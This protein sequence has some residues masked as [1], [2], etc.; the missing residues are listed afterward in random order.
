M[1]FDVGRKMRKISNSFGARE[2]TVPYYLAEFLMQLF[3]LHHLARMLRMMEIIDDDVTMT[4]EIAMVIEEI[5][6]DMEVVE[7]VDMY[8]GIK[9]KVRPVLPVVSL[10]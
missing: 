3:P 5:K 10:T 8:I 4:V 7:V 9:T 6:E 1:L 2:R